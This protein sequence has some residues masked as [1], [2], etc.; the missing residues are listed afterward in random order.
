M[1]LYAV[2]HR[3]T[4]QYLHTTKGKIVWPTVGAAKNAWLNAQP[5]RHRPR[6]FGAQ[7]DWEVIRVKIVPVD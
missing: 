2:R 5:R 7:G 1:K 4:G 3:E 6:H